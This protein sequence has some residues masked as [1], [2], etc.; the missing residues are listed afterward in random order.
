MDEAHASNTETGMS[1]QGQLAYIEKWHSVRESHD[2][3]TEECMAV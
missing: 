3:H 1:F 2:S